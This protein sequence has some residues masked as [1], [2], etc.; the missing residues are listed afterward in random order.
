MSLYAQ[1]LRE[2]LNN[3]DWLMS[4]LRAVR[5][6]GLREWCI[7]AGAIR[8]LVWDHLHGQSSDALPADIDVAYFDAR[9]INR[10][11]EQALQARL[12]A[13]APALP[14]EVTNQAA[15]HL[16]FEQ[17]FGHAVT[18]LQS[19]ADGIATWPEYATCVGVWLDAKE[20]LHIIAPHGLDDLFGLRI[21]RNP[22]RVSL[23]TYQ[24]RIAEKRYAAR[25]P[26]VSIED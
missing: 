15:V 12:Q 8:N 26:R 3:S 18:P 2:I 25:W 4:A 20:Q 11:H 6:L 23:S 21:R 24:Q 1:Q 9:E 7:G 22:S 19:L 5:A 17:H 10:T 14:W 13:L 16:W